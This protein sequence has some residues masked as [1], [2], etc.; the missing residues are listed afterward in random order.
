MSCIYMS[1]T[2]ETQ[3]KNMVDWFC[4]LSFTKICFFDIDWCKRSLNHHINQIVD[5]KMSNLRCKYSKYT[6]LLRK[7][8]NII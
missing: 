3:T 7:M 8:K 2:G 1:N 5:I 6:I 4:F